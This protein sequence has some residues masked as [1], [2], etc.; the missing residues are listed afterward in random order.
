MNPL[1]E[2][3]LGYEVATRKGAPF[4]REPIE[5]KKTPKL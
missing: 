3:T 1:N 5:D 4:F 2:G